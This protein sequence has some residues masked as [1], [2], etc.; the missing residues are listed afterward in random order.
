M[1]AA[2]VDCHPTAVIHPGAQLAEGVR[3]GPYSIIGEHVTL[4]QDT[5]VEAS[6]VVDGFTT[7]GKRNRIFPFASIGMEPQ[8]KKFQG[9]ESILEI[10]DDN[11]FRE[12]VTIHRGTSLGGGKTVVGNDNLFMAYVHIAHDCIVGHDNIFANAATLGGHI[13]VSNYVGV[14]A[15]CGIHQF[16]RIGDY[17]YLGGYTVVTQ[18]VL[19]FSLTVGNRARLYGINTVG[20]E[21]RGFSRERIAAIRGAYRVLQQSKLNISQ[22]VEQLEKDQSNEDIRLI[23]DFIRESKRG[24]VIKRGRARD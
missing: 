23:V 12:F 16:C 24:V 8:D 20:L 11:I 17:A 6:S 7:I 21:R 2:E 13:E 15:H 9:E 1:K 19:P 3:V 14:S 18:D 5:I 10:G 4:G 22:A